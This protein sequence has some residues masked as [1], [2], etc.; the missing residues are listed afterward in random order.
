MCEANDAPSGQPLQNQTPGDCQVVQCDGNGGEMAVADTNDAPADPTPDDCEMPICNGTTPGT[1]PANNGGNCTVGGVTGKCNAGQCVQ[2]VGDGDCPGQGAKC[3]M[4]M[5][6]SCSDGVMNGAETGIDC[7]G[8]CKKC[9]GD[10][11]GGNGDC[12]S[13]FCADGVCCDT[14]CTGTCLACNLTGMV[15]VCSNVP[16]N[17]DDPNGQPGCTGTSTCDGNGAC[18]GENGASC[19]ADADCL[20]NKCVSVGGGNKTCQP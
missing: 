19:N 20:S 7:G 11:C 5:C 8:A 4:G 9:D 14:A 10:T 6:V 16:L 17:T 2:C 1:T 15:G 13:T 18:K 12:K 3:V